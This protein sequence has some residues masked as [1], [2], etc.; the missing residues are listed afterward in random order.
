MKNV[1]T[2]YAL[3]LP[4]IFS[5]IL[6]PLTS[7]SAAAKAK[8]ATNPVR[9]Y[10][11]DKEVKPAVAPAFKGGR[12]YV[13]FRSVVKALGFSFNYDKA[14]QIITA[15]SE[16]VTF[17]ID[18]KN[19]KTYIDGI[20]YKYDDKYPMI[21]PSGA[22]TLVVGLL[23]E[24]T[25]YWYVEYASRKN[26]VIVYDQEFGKPKK[27]DLLAI[28]SVIEQHYGTADGHATITKCEMESWG[29]YVTMLVDVKIPKGGNELLDRMEHAT[30]KMY[31]QDDNQW[32]IY[33]N[34]SEPEY[35]DYQ[36]LSQ[37]EAEV[38]EPDKANIKNLVKSV[39]KALDEKNAEAMAELEYSDERKEYVVLYYKW[40]FLKDEEESP[41][42]YTLEEEPVI[43]RFNADKAMVYT[44][45]SM[46][47]K[48]SGDPVTL[49]FHYLM[50]AVKTSDG[51]WLNN[52]EDEIL[53]GYEKLS[54]K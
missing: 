2:K 41:V 14:N 3:I 5:L 12:T 24:A 1:L 26:A 13:E 29:T 25:D 23:F 19:G 54:D 52:P 32:A 21:I 15:K 28:R 27:S 6:L 40:R 7:I 18:V 17:K 30:I 39:V 38:P 48:D 4:M 33:D 37:K 35:L 34:Y 53:L 51:K 8:P 47:E 46:K 31:R 16:D 20:E 49:R 50:S 11:N 45:I 36:T 22:N 43:V 44:V 9:V 10:V 42:G